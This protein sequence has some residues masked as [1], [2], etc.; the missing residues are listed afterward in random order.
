[1]A[2]RHLIYDVADTGHHLEYL[3]HLL[4]YLATA[5]SDDEY[6]FV[7]SPTLRKRF[8]ALCE[9]TVPPLQHV[10]L[11]YAEETAPGQASSSD[12]S[13]IGSDSLL[14]KIA[15]VPDLLEAWKDLQSLAMREGVDH[16]FFPA[17][18]RFQLALSRWGAR[19][20]SLTFSGILF[21]PY[22]RL[23]SDGGGLKQGLT[24]RISWFRKHILMR[25]LVSNPN[26]RR[27]FLL[28]DRRSVEELRRLLGRDV[29]RYL[30]DPLPPEPD[31]LDEE[32]GRGKVRERY[33][34]NLDREIFLFFGSIRLTKGIFETLEA[35]DQLGMS[36][37]SR[38]AL[39][40]LGRTDRELAAA[41]D[42]RIRMLELG[43]SPLQVVFENRWITETEAQAVFREAAA[44]LMPYRRAEGS[45][46][47][48]GRAV[49]YGTPVIGPD[50]GL[51]GDLI[52]EYEL[53]VRV[54]SSEPGEIAG[55][56]ESMLSGDPEEFVSAEGRERFVKERSGREFARTIVRELEAIGDEV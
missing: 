18:N 39:L 49:R 6:L 34:I 22:I 12:G 40:V 15:V 14:G 2:T 21:H 37:R 8:P 42:D 47:V 30:P 51:L 10:S 52:S 9:S 19:R 32:Q 29:F 5:D 28:N 45:S 55:A 27:I 53:G 56:I 54:D 44:A 38:L 23:R 16:C 17:L 33:S 36:A 1:M 43:D 41:I 11:R 13:L 50:H 7:V 4:A 3:Y 35:L 25:L 46:G 26:V 24:A 20:S 31:D 48:L